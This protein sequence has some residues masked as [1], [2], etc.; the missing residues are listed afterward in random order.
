[1]F[2]LM[3]HGVQFT[4]TA[5]DAARYLN[6]EF[7]E[8]SSRKPNYESQNGRLYINNGTVTIVGPAMLNRTDTLAM[9]RNHGAMI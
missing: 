1:M 4:I 3:V 8:G 9:L 2:T 5:L 7:P 6:S